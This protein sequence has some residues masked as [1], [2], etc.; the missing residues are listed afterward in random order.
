[1]ESLVIENVRSALEKGTLI[2]MV[3]EQKGK[4]DEIVARAK[5][6]PRL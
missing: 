2:T 3:A 5:A 6:S 1:M 4:E